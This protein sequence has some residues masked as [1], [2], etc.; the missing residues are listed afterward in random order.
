MF[1]VFSHQKLAKKLSDGTLTELHKLYYVTI[2]LF[3]TTLVSS[4]ILNDQKYDLNIYDYI[5]DIVFL[6]VT[7][8]AF[9]VIYFALNFK[10]AANYIIVS[11]SLSIPIS[12]RL[13]VGS[14]IVLAITYLL[15]GDIYFDPDTGET[16]PAWV[17][18]VLLLQLSY[19]WLFIKTV[20]EFALP[21]ADCRTN[22]ES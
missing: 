2:Y 12:L 22:T 14:L 5:V 4:S 16:Q 7:T 13:F 17:G 8:L 1:I 20:R 9:L 6:I 3:L 19:Y 10:S 11:A 18:F 21:Q 15:F